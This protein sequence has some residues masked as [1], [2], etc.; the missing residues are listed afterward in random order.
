MKCGV[1]A[2]VSY[3]QADRAREGLVTMM[4]EARHCMTSWTPNTFND[5]EKNIFGLPSQYYI[6]LCW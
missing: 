4:W 5:P 2:R 1:G 6:D 3:V